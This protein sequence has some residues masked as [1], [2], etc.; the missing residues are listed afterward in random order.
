MRTIRIPE[1]PYDE[2]MRLPVGK[3]SPDPRFDVRRA[4]ESEFPLV[5]DCVDAAFG[6]VRPRPL[7]EWLYRR[8][9]YGRAQVWMVVERATERVL[10]TGANF[11]WPVWRDWEEIAGAVSGDAAT[12]P[13]WQR[14]GLSEIRRTV[15]RSHPWQG[16]RCSISGPN[17]NS[18]AVSA[19]DGTA[20]KILGALP[21][22]VLPLRAVEDPEDSTLPTPL[23]EMMNR[24]LAAA[25]SAWHSLTL[26]DG[27]DLRMEEIRRF[28][29]E[30]DVATLQTMHFPGYWCP[31]GWQFLNWRY[32]DHPTESYTAIGLRRRDTL[33]GYAVVRLTGQRAMLAEF[34]VSDSDRAAASALLDGAIGLAREAGCMAL[35]F[36]GTPSWRHWGLFRRAGMLPVK[37]SNFMEISYDADP[38]GSL[39][40]RNW[41]LM[42]GDRDYH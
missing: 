8:N 40:P 42:P 3:S 2:F 4:Q 30:H 6:K 10:K 9:P 23:A 26:R 37:S 35:T 16:K 28:D 33:L 20:H 17:E 11:P 12:V 13:E 29:A 18:R 19:K 41:Q 36:F 32:L 38:E 39:D 27:G 24:T 34:A 5:Y 31:H 25:V 1:D 21:G 7:Y 22:G 14:K 15:R